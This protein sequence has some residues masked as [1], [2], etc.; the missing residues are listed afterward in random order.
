MR[1]QTHFGFETVGTDEK[2]KKVMGVFS[3]VASKYDIM[4]DAMSMGMHRLWKMRM[5]GTAA[6]RHGQT[7]LDVAA[8]SGDISIGLLK[9]MGG[10]GRVV[11]TD[12][13]G[14]M[15]REGARRVIDAGYLPGRAD[16]IQSDGSKLPFAENSFDCVTI[17]FGIRNF[18][19]IAAGLAEF[20]RVL[21][22]GGQFLCLEFSKP[23][24]PLLD[25]VYDAYSFNIIPPMGELIAGDRASY[26]YLVESIR[27]FPDQQRFEKM[28]GKA[29]FELVR[30][31]NMTG[32]IVALHRGYKL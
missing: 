24:L 28:L 30:H 11:L 21:K 5:L 31:D 20:H 17:A 26:Q 9:K 22:P 15:L 13:N 32:G 4:N 2:E 27:R 10:K 1:Q 6:V 18:V 12:L 3:S 19:D 14:P 29:G 16:C 25:V 23:V 8:G 7:A